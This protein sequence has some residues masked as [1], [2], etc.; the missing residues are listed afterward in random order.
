MIE[1]S[2]L[3][4]LLDYAPLTGELTWKIALRGSYVGAPAGTL[5]SKGYIRVSIRGKYYRA[6]RII[7]AIQTG[8]W[9]ARNIEIDHKNRIRTDNRWENLLLKTSS[10]N[11]HNTGAHKD[12]TSG[13]VGVTWSAHRK[14]WV[15]QL[16]VNGKN[17]NLGGFA[18]ALEASE[19]YNAAK[20]I[21]HPSAFL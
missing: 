10:E 5:D 2:E 20:R 8:K 19:V 3:P 15:A 21:H 18:T 13:Y 11:S 9:P 17:L 14:K 7:W 6:H 4:K 1:A 12:N 16:A